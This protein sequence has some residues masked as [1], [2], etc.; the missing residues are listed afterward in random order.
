MSLYAQHPRPCCP[1]CRSVAGYN[2]GRELDVVRSTRLAI[3]LRCRLCHYEW[4]ST[5][6]HAL[7]WRLDRKDAVPENEEAVDIVPCALCNNPNSRFCPGC[8][9]FSNFEPV[10]AKPSVQPTTREGLGRLTMVV[11]SVG[12][13]APS[14]SGCVRYVA[15]TLP[16]FPIG[17]AWVDL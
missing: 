5:N 6:D 10:V 9:E 1:K 4:R 12:V 13:V 8:V 2:L 3:I 15:F 16:L 14:D 17:N 7:L 11:A